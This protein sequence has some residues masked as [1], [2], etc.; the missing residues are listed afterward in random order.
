MSKSI[1]KNE[2]IL[3]EITISIS[4]ALLRYRV[5]TQSLLRFNIRSIETMQHDVYV[6]LKHGLY[7]VI[8]R[9][10]DMMFE[11]CPNSGYTLSFVANP[12]DV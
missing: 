10:S 4:E 8:R 7:F 1:H 11:C 12:L 5:L 3:L 6:L 2:V 9:D